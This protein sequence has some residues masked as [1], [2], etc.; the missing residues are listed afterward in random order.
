MIIQNAIQVNDEFLVSEHVH[1]YKH[2]IIKVGKKKEY[3]FMVDG[4]TDYLKGSVVEV[5]DSTLKRHK[6]KY[7]DLRLTTENSLDV[8]INHLLVM[9]DKNT[10]EWMFLKDLS[11]VQISHVMHGFRMYNKKQEDLHF[12]FL[13]YRYGQLSMKKSLELLKKDFGI[14]K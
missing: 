13:R 6:I 8:I 11:L 1:D 9:V 4:G 5:S 2:K 14:T 3:Y 10:K 12:L 7:Q